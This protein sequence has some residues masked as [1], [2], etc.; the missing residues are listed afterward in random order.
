MRRK[1]SFRSE[2]IGPENRNKSD[3]RNAIVAMPAHFRSVANLKN[4]KG[5]EVAGSAANI[6]S[7]RMFSLQSAAAVT[8]ARATKI[9]ANTLC[10]LGRRRDNSNPKRI[11]R[12]V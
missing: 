12:L 2:S 8:R 11:K 5:S 7:I 9:I 10:G 3:E 1:E 4:A 6:R